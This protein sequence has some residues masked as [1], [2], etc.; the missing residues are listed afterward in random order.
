[1]PALSALRSGT[2]ELSRDEFFAHVRPITAEDSL[3]DVVRD[4]LDDPAETAVVADLL[5]E[6]KRHGTFHTPLRIE[7]GVLVNGHHRFTALVVSGAALYP[8]DVDQENH[9]TENGTT[10]VLEVRPD[11]GY[12]HDHD[13]FMNAALCSA[14]SLPVPGGWV[15]SDGGGMTRSSDGI[16]SVH[17]T[18]YEDFDTA[19]AAVPLIIERLARFG[20]VATLVSVADAVW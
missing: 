7:D 10:V 17:Y 8:V 4:L 13:S 18:Y 5:V 2:Y 15:E 6:L 19:T 14:R 11:E 12:G 1:M 16:D 20:V 3:E 9:E